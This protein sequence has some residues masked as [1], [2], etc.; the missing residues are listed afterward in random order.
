[1]DLSDYTKFQKLTLAFFL[2]FFVTLFSMGVLFMLGILF[3]VLFGGG[4]VVRTLTFIGYTLSVGIPC[5]YICKNIPVSITFAPIV[6]SASS[7]LGAVSEPDF[8]G[9][10]FMYV[11][12][13]GAVLAG[14]TTGFIMGRYRIRQV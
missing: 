12:V 11:I 2:S 10:F 7:I 9:P 5:F 14:A 8:W 6:C 3:H 1:M 13:W 4:L